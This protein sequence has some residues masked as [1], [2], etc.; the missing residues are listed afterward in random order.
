MA[1]ATGLEIN[2]D[3]NIPAN[4][5]DAHR[6]IHLAAK[7]HKQHEAEEILFKA[8]FTEGKDVA[9]TETLKT[10]GTELG[11]PQDELNELLTSDKYADEVKY[12]LHESKQL[13]IRGVPFFLLN[14]KYALSGAQPVEAFQGAL[15]HS[16]Q[17]WKSEQKSATIKSLNTET[18]MTCDDS[19]CQI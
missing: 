4:S 15:S 13:G 1:R 16:F 19:G 12:D 5:F 14:R 17:E 11:L 8:H 10:I 6:L 9:K 3:K 2:F 18:D 7:H